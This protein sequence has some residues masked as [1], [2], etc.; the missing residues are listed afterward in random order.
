M[1]VVSKNYQWKN[2]KNIRPKIEDVVVDILHGD[3]LKNA[4]DFF[5]YLRAN[6]MNPQWSSANAWKIN[7]KKQSVC[8]IRA[9]GSAHYNDLNEP[10]SWHIQPYIG[11]YNESQLSDE[12]KQVVWKNIKH[13]PFCGN[14][15]LKF[16]TIFGKEY[17]NACEGK[18]AFKN[19]NVEAIECAKKLIELRR[20]AIQNNK[21]EK[22]TYIP[23]NRSKL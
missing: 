20:E 14:C 16:R 3:A 23:A 2:Q 15:R 7:Y 22:H 9:Y 11:E 21:V 6:K 10:G 17:H 8:H 1:S 13:C 19:P 18:I 12:F 4:L 5:A